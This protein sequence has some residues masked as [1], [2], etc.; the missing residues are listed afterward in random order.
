MSSTVP[1]YYTIGEAAVVLQR[2][3]SQVSRYIKHGQL[4][5]VDLG[6]QKL[7]EQGVVHAFK[8]PPPGNPTFRKEP[9]T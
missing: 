5:A 2:S 8:P 6:H 3:E 1:G 9:A 7:L 4:P